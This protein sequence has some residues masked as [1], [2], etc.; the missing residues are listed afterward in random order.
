MYKI[1]NWIVSVLAV[2]FIANTV[3]PA[4][5]DQKNLQDF[6]GNYVG[7]NAQIVGEGISDRDLNLVVRRY[8]NDGFTLI[9][10]S[11][12]HK[13]GGKVKRIRHLVN[14]QPVRDRP[15]IFLA[16]LSKSR[17]GDRLSLDPITG[18]PYIW[19]G[20]QD[21]T[22]IVH[23]FYITDQAGYEIH[24]YKRTLTKDGM[25]L[26]WERTRDGENLKLITAKLKKVPN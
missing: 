14:F 6:F 21:K 24:V 11:V 22:L 26:R 5:A 8:K 12:L 19:A 17:S 23:T 1:S 25:N 4:N 18:D 2:F 10:T 9:W 15:G 16:E 13:K 20:V 3:L 7:R